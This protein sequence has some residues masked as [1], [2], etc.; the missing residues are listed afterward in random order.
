MGVLAF[1]GDA[2][3]VFDSPSQLGHRTLVVGILP[4]CRD[5]VGVF[6]RPEPTG[7]M[8]LMDGSTVTSL[9]HV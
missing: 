5:V 8:N 3:G 4:L 9:R 6:Y 2:V 1:C 7:L